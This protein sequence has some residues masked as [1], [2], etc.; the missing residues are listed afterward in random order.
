[1]MSKVKRFRYYK[2]DSTHKKASKSKPI[3]Y[4]I[5]GMGCHSVFS[6]HK[7]KDG[8]T[9]I[10]R[11]KDGVKRMHYLHRYVYEIEVGEIPKGQV[12]MHSCDNPSCINIQ[13]LSL[14]TNLDNLRDMVQKGRSSFGERN[15][16]AKLSESDIFKILSDDRDALTISKEFGVTRT[17]IYLIKARKT[18]SHLSIA[19]E[20]GT[21][22]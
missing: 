1:M 18:W 11:R 21:I 20:K 19:D 3:E 13:H 8:Y 2:A 15:G 16:K 6:H 10:L 7:D 12:V 22:E 9:R 5:N 14:G 4:V 17:H